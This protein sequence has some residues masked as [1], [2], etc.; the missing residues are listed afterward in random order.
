MRRTKGFTLI[1]LITAIV[2]ISII[3]AAG[4]P[5]LVNSVRAYNSTLNVVMTLDKLRYASERMAH[6]FREA[7]RATLN[8][9]TTAPQFTKIDYLISGTT[10]T[11]TSYG[12]T[13]FGDTSTGLVTISYSGGTATR[14]TLTDQLSSTANPLKFT[15]YDQNGATTTSAASVRYVDIQ[16]I[17]RANGQDYSERTRVAIRNP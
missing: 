15:Y 12:I 10:I 2:V 9:S 4:A 1:E 13:L 3:A 16:L 8:M 6:E 7:S 14:A 11:S 17:L 5:V